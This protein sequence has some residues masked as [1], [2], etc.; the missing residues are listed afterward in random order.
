MN[1]KV[2]V[3][4]A[5]LVLVSFSIVPA[6]ACLT[7]KD[8]SGGSWET[9]DAT[10]PCSSFIGPAPSLGRINASPTYLTALQAGRSQTLALP[11]LRNHGRI[12]PLLFIPFLALYFGLVQT[13]PEVSAVSEIRATLRAGL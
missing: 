12:S 9:S 8:M 11:E 2:K 7:A 3:V 1:V 10:D 13:G 6:H 5:C 4:L